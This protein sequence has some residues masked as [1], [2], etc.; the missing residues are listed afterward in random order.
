[1]ILLAF[2]AGC[3][4]V[5]P[6]PLFIVPCLGMGFLLWQYPVKPTLI[7]FALGICV[8]FIHQ[9][10]HAPLATPNQNTLHKANL[11]GEII[12]LPRYRQNKLSFDIRVQQLNKKS[13]SFIARLSCYRQCPQVTIGD[14]VSLQA[15]L[16]KPH[17]YQNPGSF[18]FEQWAWANH[19][20]RIGSFY[21]KSVTTHP[22]KKSKNFLTRFSV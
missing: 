4:I 22:F 6:V 2:V 16:K 9:W 13:V 1:M 3:A 17:G 15:T 18:L 5:L 8:T 14:L 19:I 20:D 10:L 21:P 12:H 11:V 7:L